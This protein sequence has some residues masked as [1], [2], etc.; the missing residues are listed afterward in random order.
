MTSKH[1]SRSQRLRLRKLGPPPGPENEGAVVLGFEEVDPDEL[2]LVCEESLFSSEKP[3]WKNDPSYHWRRK[4]IQ[5][6]KRRK[7]SKP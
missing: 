2:S 1:L 3:S 4:T 5:K 7:K 6:R